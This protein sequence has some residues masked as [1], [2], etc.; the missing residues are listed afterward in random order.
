VARAGVVKITF[1]VPYRC[2]FGQHI[3]LVGSEDGLGKW[4]VKRGLA[5][6]WTDGDVWT[7]DLEL[8]AKWVHGVD[9]VP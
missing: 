3:C 1:A 9:A 7:A 6:Q 8:Q 5:M 4:D 2:Y